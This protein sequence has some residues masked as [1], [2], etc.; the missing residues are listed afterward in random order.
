MDRRPP[1]GSLAIFKNL[2]LLADAEL[3]GDVDLAQSANR[4]QFEYD[5]D[6]LFAVLCG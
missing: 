3:A 1:P 6:G 2:A 4:I 5:C